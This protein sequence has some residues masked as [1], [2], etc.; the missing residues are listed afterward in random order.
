MGQHPT[1]EPF[2]VEVVA[3]MGYDDIYPTEDLVQGPD[4]ML[5]VVQGTTTVKYRYGVC[6]ALAEKFPC[7]T[8]DEP[9]LKDVGMLNVLFAQIELSEDVGTCFNVPQQDLRAL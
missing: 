5:V 9:L 1:I 8:D 2:C 4:N 3:V 7:G 6:F